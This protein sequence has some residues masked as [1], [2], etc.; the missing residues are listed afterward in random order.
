ML[1]AGNCIWCL[2]LSV[3]CLFSQIRLLFFR[4]ALLVC[5][6]CVCGWA[7]IVYTYTHPH[8]NQLVHKALRVYGCEPN[9]LCT[10][11]WLWHE[12]SIE[13][14]KNDITSWITTRFHVDLIYLW[15]LPTCVYNRTNSLSIPLQLFAYYKA[16]WRVERGVVWAQQPFSLSVTA[17]NTYLDGRLKLSADTC[18]YIHYSKHPC[19]LGWFSLRA[20]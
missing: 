8:T 18:R 14:E 15:F 10:N 4:L 13:H 19:T 7:I 1:I 12:L 17:D 9:K 11:F 2:V 6:I 16:T 3:V 20:L 5:E